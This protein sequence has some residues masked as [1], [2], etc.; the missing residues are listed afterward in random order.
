MKKISRLLLLLIMALSVSSIAN[1]AALY[2]KTDGNDTKNCSSWADACLTISRAVTVAVA[3]DEIRIAKGVY[4]FSTTLSISGKSLS[5]IGGYNAAIGKQ[6]G[7]KFSTIISGDKDNNDTVDTRGITVTYSNIVGN[8]TIKAV[9]L[10]DG[11]Y[12][13]KH[14]TFTGFKGAQADDHGAVIF[15]KNPIGVNNTLILNDVALMGNQSYSMG[16]IMAYAILPNAASIV[17]DDGWFQ[18]NAGD[19]GIVT[20]HQNISS[21]TIS[22]SVFKD[23][24]S[25]NDGVNW[26]R[27]VGAVWAQS[28]TSLKVSNSLFSGNTATDGA[29]AIQADNTL[30]ITNSTFFDNVSQG[31]AAIKTAST[32][33]IRYSTIYS[34]DGNGAALSG[35]VQHGST[36]ANSLLLFAN[37]ILANKKSAVD[38]N[39]YSEDGT[40]KDLGY[41]RL[42]Y[43][44]L[45]YVTGTFTK[46]LTTI[47]P[48][49]GES[50][51]VVGAGY[52]G[53][54]RDSVKIKKAGPAHNIV[55]NDG[56]PFYGVGKSADYP[57][58]SIQQAHGALKRA[59]YAAGYYYFDL[60][61][62]Y[63][64]LNGFTYTPGNG[65]LQFSTYVDKQGYVLIASADAINN[66]AAAYTTTDALALRSDQMMLQSVLAHA[67]FEFNEVRISSYSNGLRGTFDGYSKSSN[68]VSAIKSFISLPNPAMGGAVWNVT[69]SSSGIN[70]FTGL[71][72]G[73]TPLNQQIYHAN[74]ESGIHWIPTR[75]NEALLY[76]GNP[77]SNSTPSFGDSLDLWVRSNS[78]LCDGSISS[79]DARGLPKSDRVDS[80]EFA[81]N[82]DVGSFEF[83]D[84][85]K[86]DC[87]DED[88]LRQENNYLKAKVGFCIS[89]ISDITPKALIDNIGAVTPI[90]LLLL[91]LTGGYLRLRQKQRR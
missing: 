72:F 47:Y 20:T 6:E 25:I 41:N 70:Y 89:D 45:S 77:D 74:G 39:I 58:V 26:D 76:P 12:T 79:V 8:N 90:H 34:N 62:D 31:S 86:I 82:C 71:S 2:V 3:G 64:E 59:D 38:Q 17:I 18:N 14:L 44:S 91:I 21:L 69:H 48:A 78:G 13:F 53:G 54:L 65:S 49:K 81:A 63:D 52:F 83:N 10:G 36:T 88:G 66:T 32:T 87:A 24:V 85:Y 42:G 73:Q 57:F 60:G 51:I 67:K 75:P 22:N 46:Q 61:G 27:G 37:L 15:Y 29:A 30:E 43:V 28:S 33:S 11:S 7:D 5:F 56:I 68:V 19:A 55:P 84:Y 23:N 80:S 4:K 16:N 1:A 40:I 9:S 50:D 35:G